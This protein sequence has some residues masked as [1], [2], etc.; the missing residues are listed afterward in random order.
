MK[1]IGSTLLFLVLVLGLTTLSMAQETQQQSGQ[2]QPMSPEGELFLQLQ[3]NQNNPAKFVEL[4]EEFIEKYPDSP[5]MPYIRFSATMAYQ[6]L[7]N[8]E[9]MI[10][11][12]EAF[13]EL[14]PN[15]PVIPATLANA[16][17]EDHQIERAEK[18]ANTSIAIID[19]LE[20]PAQV[21]QAQWEQQLNQLKCAVHATLGYVHLQKASALDKEKDEE[22]RFKELDKSIDEFKTAIKANNRDSISYYRLGLSYALRDEVEES[23]KTY[24]KAVVL[25]GAGSAEAKTDMEQ[26]LTKLEENNLLEG[27]SIDKYLAEAK[28]D[29]GLQ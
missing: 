11:H 6:T 24:A 29:L 4:A 25:G 5:N 23:L 27:R 21:D 1:K 19:S 20:K 17:A 8:M 3:Q 28:N 26:I 22:A 13:M 10:E 9:R 14:I 7:N 2:D 15:N 16:Y 12:G 18:L